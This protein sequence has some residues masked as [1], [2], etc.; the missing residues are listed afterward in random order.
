MGNSKS[1][2]VSYSPVP[3]ISE[4]KISK[5]KNEIDFSNIIYDKIHENDEKNNEARKLKFERLEERKRKF[6]DICEE[7][8]E[9]ILE[10][11]KN[12]SFVVIDEK[13]MRIVFKYMRPNKFQK[14]FCV[15]NDVVL[16]INSENFPAGNYDGNY[17]NVRMHTYIIDVIRRPRLER[18]FMNKFIN[19]FVGKIKITSMHFKEIKE[20]SI[21]GYSI[22][23]NI[24]ID[25]TPS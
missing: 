16:N 24:K 3:Q 11:I 9:E 19:M 14:L 2:V 5:L 10:K 7:I 1:K 4:T 15:E 17:L 20:K 25:T 23:V 18:W 21:Y 12:K 22:D 8:M 13:N 6:N